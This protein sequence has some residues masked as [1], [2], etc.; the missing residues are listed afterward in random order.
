[1]ADADDEH[2]E[3]LVPKLVEDPV[4]AHSKSPDPLRSCAGQE[5]RTR[6]TRVL[7][8]LAQCPPDPLGHPFGGVVQ[9]TLRAGNEANRVRRHAPR[10]PL[11]AVQLGFDFLE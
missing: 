4:V 3:V 1:M 6:R 9:L 7:P 8:K 10:S 5:F 11:P 2:E